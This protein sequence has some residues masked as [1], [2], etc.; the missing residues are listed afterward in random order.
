MVLIEPLL[1]PGQEAQ[2][3]G[4]VHRFGQT[5]QTHV[6]RFVVQHTVEENVAALAAARAAAMDL[7]AASG[8][9]AGAGASGV[10][11]AEAGRLSV[12]DV[13]ALLSTHWR[14][15]DPQAVVTLDA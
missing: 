12:G 3:I 10:G 6:H 2:A 9:L 1:N 8:A 14:E 15:A 13:G 5:R 7:A 4:R 11:G